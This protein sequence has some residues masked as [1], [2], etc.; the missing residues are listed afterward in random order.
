MRAAGWM[1]AAAMIGTAILSPSAAAASNHRTAAQGCGT[2]PIDVEVVL[3]AS[4]SMSSNSNGGHTRSYWAQSAVKGLIDQLD[5]NG[6]VG[7]GA[8]TS[9]GGRHRVGLTTYGGETATVASALGSHDAAGTKGLIPSGTAA[10]TPFKLAMSTAAADLAAN[11]R[12]T[13]F[14]MAV[15]HVLIVLSDGRPNPDPAMRPSG[16][17]IASF[18]AAAD[19]VISIAIGSGGSGPSE[20]DLGLMESLAKP[21]DAS[22]YA[23]V[24]DSSA[25][26]AM[27]AKIFQTIACPTPTPSPSDTPT[28]TPSESA[29]TPVESESLPPSDSPSPS[30]SATPSPSPSDSPT[31]SPSESPSESAT[32]SE[33]PSSPVESESASPSASSTPSGTVE[34]AT[35]T[36]AAT[37][38]STDTFAVSGS[39]PSDGWRLLL[40]ATALLLAVVLVTTPSAAKRR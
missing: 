37:P 1:A 7:T 16:S 9:S 40:A 20:V 31:A 18:R 27:F 36:P 13:D 10:G 34:G 26:P 35:G 15:E 3:D 11:E 17:Q 12:S 4:S 25:L 6:G 14:G 28:P 29:S 30:E 33:S 8:A 22:H 23:N 21:D 24:V 2:K 39:G 19:E 5:A 32:P 38:P